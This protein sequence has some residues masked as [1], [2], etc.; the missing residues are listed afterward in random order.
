MTKIGIEKI[1]LIEYLRYMRMIICGVS[2][3]LYLR[4]VYIKI[5]FNH[6]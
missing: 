1:I 5:I 3:M 2:G 4:G 6:L